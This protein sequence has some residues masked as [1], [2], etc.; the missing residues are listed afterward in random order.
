MPLTAPHLEPVAKLCV[1]VGQPVEAGVVHSASLSGKRRII[2]ITGGTVTGLLNGRVLEGGADFQII[3]SDT[4]AVL[5]ARYIL[6]LASGAR[7]YVQNHALRR[8]SAENIAKLA[9]G[10]VVDPTAI[11]FRCAPSFE[12]SDPSL[13]WLTESLFVGVGARYPDRVEMQFFRVA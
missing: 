2:P 4:L 5:D 12:V 6:E 8:G 1:T 9:R 10:E 7:V 3:V 11:Y 13:S